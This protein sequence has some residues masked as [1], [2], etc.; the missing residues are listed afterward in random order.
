MIFIS[1][2]TSENPL[3]SLNEEEIQKKLY[4]KFHKSSQSQNS[5]SFNT[6]STRPQAAQTEPQE[7]YLKKGIDTLKSIPWKFTLITVGVVIVTIYLFQGMSEFFHQ[8]SERKSA[9]PPVIEKS[10]LVATPKAAPIVKTEVS[11][12]VTPIESSKTIAVPKKNYYAVQICTY[13]KESDAKTLE[14]ELNK[15]GFAAFNLRMQGQHQTS[16][17]VVF[18]GKNESYSSAN[19]ALKEFRKSEQYQRFPDAFIRSV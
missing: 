11:K 2:K 8:L 3:R 15:L 16:Y 10:V 17:Y 12:A 18:I 14:N 19:N 4:G 1:K 13:Q 9:V 7:S 6:S 5:S